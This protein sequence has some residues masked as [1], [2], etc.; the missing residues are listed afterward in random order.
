[1]IHKVTSL[2]AYAVMGGNAGIRPRPFTDGVFFFREACCDRFCFGERVA[3]GS[4]MVSV[5]RLALL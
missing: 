5:F 2:G 4:A 3:T 1:M